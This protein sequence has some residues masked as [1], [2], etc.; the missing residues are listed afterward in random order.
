MLEHLKSQESFTL[1]PLAFL[2]VVQLELGISFVRTRHLLEFFDPEMEPL[3]D[4]T[5]IEGYWKGLLRGTWP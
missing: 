1:T 4:S 2:K 5:V 3:A